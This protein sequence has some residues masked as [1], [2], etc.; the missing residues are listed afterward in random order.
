MPVKR[1]LIDDDHVS[2]ALAASCPDH[3]F[4]ASPLPVRPGC[5]Q[6]FIVSVLAWIPTQ[7][8]PANRVDPDTGAAIHNCGQNLLCFVIDSKKY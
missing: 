2:K 5:R 1:G 3:A 4:H 8:P 7:G 6:Y